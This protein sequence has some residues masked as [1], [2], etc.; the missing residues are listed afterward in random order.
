MAAKE[1]F[2]T[3]GTEK[4]S[5]KEVREK[6]ENYIKNGLKCLTIRHQKTQPKK[7]KHEKNHLKWGFFFLCEISM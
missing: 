4:D 1:E 3:E 6:G 2:K 7:P 5:L